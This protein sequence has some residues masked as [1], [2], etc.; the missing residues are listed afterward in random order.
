MLKAKLIFRY[1]K[2]TNTKKNKGFTLIELLVVVIII[3]ILST[4]ALPSLVRQVEKSRQTEAKIALGNI[5]RSQQANRFEFGTFTTINQLPIKLMGKYYTYADV[6]TPDAF[7]AVH[8]AT[9]ITQF[10]N[11]LKDYSSAV[12]QIA[13]GAYKGIVCEQNNIDGTTAPIP[14]TVSAGIPSCSTGTTLIF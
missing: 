1:L 5:N 8:T 12:G 10:E 9:V 4:V 14:A 3:G 7:Q 2:I 13:S 11:D 6:G